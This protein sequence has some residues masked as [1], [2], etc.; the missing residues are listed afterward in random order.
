MAKQTAIA[1]ATY[2]AY[3]DA[4]HADVSV[5]AV[6]TGIP[7]GRT[8]CGIVA[9]ATDD[10]NFWWLVL[11]DDAGTGQVWIVERNAGAN[12]VRAS[13]VAT[14]TG[15][16]SLTL[17]C[18]GNELRGFLD[19]VQVVQYLSATFNNTATRFGLAE[20][21]NGAYVGPTGYSYFEVPVP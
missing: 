21:N 20:F 12:V 3:S 4:G 18:S 15:D 11:E 19:G 13:A 9:R 8:A 2:C 14:I 5:T 6:L 7:A 17:T 16:H 10:Q 1:G